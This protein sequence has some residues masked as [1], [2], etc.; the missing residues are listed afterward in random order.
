MLQTFCDISV[1]LSSM[2]LLHAPGQGVSL[3]DAVSK[4]FALMRAQNQSYVMATTT[5]AAHQTAN[6]CRRIFAIVF[7]FASS[8]ISLS[9]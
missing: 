3:V 6:H 9:K 1:P 4:L 2:S 5:L 8:S 7:P